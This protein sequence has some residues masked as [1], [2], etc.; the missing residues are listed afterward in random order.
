[1]LRAFSLNQI[2]FELNYPNFNPASY[3]HVVSLSVPGLSIS[4]IGKLKSLQIVKKMQIVRTDHETKIPQTPNS[5][6]E[7]KASTILSLNLAYNFMLEALLRKVLEQWRGLKN[8]T[9]RIPGC[10]DGKKYRPDY[11]PELGNT[12]S[13]ANA[14]QAREPI[15]HFPTELRTGKMYSRGQIR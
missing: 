6:L 14:A 13:P 5:N 12:L 15:K 11:G 7:V 4:D 8:L 2:Y 3:L 1:M 9:F 10:K